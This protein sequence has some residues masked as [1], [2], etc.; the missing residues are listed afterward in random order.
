M[1]RSQGRKLY[2]YIYYSKERHIND[3][4]ID[5]LLSS[6]S[7]TNFKVYPLEVKSSKNYTA[8]FYEKFKIKFGNRI[9]KS[10]FVHPKNLIVNENETRLPP[11]MLFL[12]C[13]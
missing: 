13:N 3:I 5:F 11:Y 2:F 12:L 4:E 1:L 6:E 8:T 9:S 10:F 7:K